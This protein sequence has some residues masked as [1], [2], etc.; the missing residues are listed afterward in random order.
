M[1]NTEKGQTTIL[2]IK[3]AMD[4]NTETCVLGLDKSDFQY[5]IQLKASEYRTSRRFSLRIR[6]KSYDAQARK[7]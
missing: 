1:R 6:Y 7:L 5:P 2:T 4:F 3:R